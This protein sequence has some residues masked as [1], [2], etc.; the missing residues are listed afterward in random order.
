M[1][2]ILSDIRSNGIFVFIY[3]NTVDPAALAIH[4]KEKTFIYIYI[5]L[6][7]FRLGALYIY[8]W[9]KPKQLVLTRWLPGSLTEVAQI[10]PLVIPLQV[11]EFIQPFPVPSTFNQCISSDRYD[12]NRT[13]NCLNYLRWEHIYKRL[14]IKCEDLFPMGLPDFRILSGDKGPPKGPIPGQMPPY[15]AWDAGSLGGPANTYT[16]YPGK[17]VYKVYIYINAVCQAVLG[18]MYMQTFLTPMN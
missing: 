11:K 10:D 17:L 1:E 3:R 2:G 16:G 9:L 15:A 13:E 7:K 12:H 5:M 8:M 18:A 6:L 14:E 4:F